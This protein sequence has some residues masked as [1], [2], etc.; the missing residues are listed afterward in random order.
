MASIIDSFRDVFTDKNSFVKI[1][2]LTIPVYFSYVYYV[3]RSPDFIWLAGVTIFLLFGFL[4]K[5]SSRVLNDQ[6]SVLPSLNPFPLLWAAL[7]G[8]IAI[9]PITLI[10]CFLANY[11][12]S[13]INIIPWLDITLKTCFWLTAIA[14][15][16]TSFLMFITRE[17]II[18]SYRIKLL[19]DKAG[20]IIVVL[21][22]YIV[23]LV[24]INAP[25]AG[26]LGYT[27]FILFGMGDFLI[28]FIAFAITFNIGALGH[29]LAQS[30]Y[31][32]LEKELD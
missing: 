7:K 28:F 21:I 4:A 11:V 8:I 24:V 25:T 32:V 2:V 18:D 27:I 12:C 20:D 26:I 17:S 1:L 14:V 3:K 22:V 29:Y 5:V 31:D 23:Q 10:S 13:L 15:S 6:D 19:F 9:G 30:H 16:L